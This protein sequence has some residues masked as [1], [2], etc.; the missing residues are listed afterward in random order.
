MIQQFIRLL[1]LLDIQHLDLGIQYRI[2]VP[3]HIFKDILYSILLGF[4]TDQTEEKRSPFV[5]ADSI[6]NKA[7]PP[8]LEMKS[9]PSGWNSGIGCV[10]TP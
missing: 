6:M 3:I 7:V 4:P 1:D 9:T 8:E 10:N 5:S 2:K